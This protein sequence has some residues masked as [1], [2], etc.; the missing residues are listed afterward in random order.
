LMATVFLSLGVALSFLTYR[1]VRIAWKL[2]LLLAV[3][4]IL[5]FLPWVAYN[6]YLFLSGGSPYV[7]SPG[8]IYVVVTEAI[9]FVIPA[10]AVLILAYLA[11]RDLKGLLFKGKNGP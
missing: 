4:A 7:D 6:V 11:R 1:D 9:L 5:R 10:S 8:T 3:L 2:C